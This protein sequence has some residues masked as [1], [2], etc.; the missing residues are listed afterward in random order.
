MRQVTSWGVPGHARASGSCP[1]LG[2]DRPVRPSGEKGTSSVRPA[3]G[4]GGQPGPSTQSLTPFLRSS[5]ALHSWGSEG[6]CNSP[7][8]FGEPPGQ[9]QG[10][11]GSGHHPS[12]SQHGLSQESVITQ[13]RLHCHVGGA[14][15]GTPRPGLGGR[16]GGGRTTVSPGNSAS[17]EAQPSALRDDQARAL[18]DPHPRGVRTGNRVSRTRLLSPSRPLRLRTAAVLPL[19]EVGDET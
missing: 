14:G 7:S 3:M 2:K 12:E 17:P 11:P 6:H 18:R 10:I 4:P 13:R 16:G 9:P 8:P 5:A 1:G 15:S 19:S